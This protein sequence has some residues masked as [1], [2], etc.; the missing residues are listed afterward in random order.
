M[1]VDRSKEKDIDKS[2]KRKGDLLAKLN[3]VKQEKT[4]QNMGCFEQ[5][6]IVLKQKLQIDFEL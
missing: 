6:P 5:Q 1:L 4:G 3:K 2:I